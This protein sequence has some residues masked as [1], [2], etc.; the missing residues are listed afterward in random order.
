M[1]NDNGDDKITPRAKF[2][3]AMIF[4]KQKMP[5]REG[6]KELLPPTR[7]GVFRRRADRKQLLHDCNCLQLIEPRDIP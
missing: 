2:R 6:T 5:G 7:R 4:R 3:R 1:S